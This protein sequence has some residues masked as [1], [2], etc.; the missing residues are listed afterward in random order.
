[1]AAE[2]TRARSLA[3]G[4]EGHSAIFQ[5]YRKVST[6]ARHRDVF[7][8]GAVFEHH[9][10]AMRLRI[11]N[12]HRAVPVRLTS[13]IAAK[14]EAEGKVDV[15]L[16]SAQFPEDRSFVPSEFKATENLSRS[17]LDLGDFSKQMKLPILVDILQRMY[18]ESDAEYLIYTNVDIGLYPDFYTKVNQF[19]E[20]GLDAFIINRRRISEEYIS[21][22][23]LVAIYKDKGKKHPGFDCFVFHRDLFPKLVLKEVCIGVPFIGITL[24]QNLFALSK[25]FKL[26]ENE[27][28]TFHIGMEIIKGRASREYFKY[29]QKQF[30]SAMNSPLREHLAVKKLPYSH[31]LL[32]FRLI[33]WGLQPS[34]PIRLML[35]LEMER[36]AGYFRKN[37]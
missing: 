21:V 8:D 15:E 36:L 3:Y 28:L 5:P 14:K 6:I 27:I 19:I 31:L 13:M 11:E 17:V 9:L 16:L 23:D 37:K 10:G 26:Y 22:D 1:M 33:R 7:G 34:F 29:N 32:P 25:N 24:S 18:E 20:S 4:P 12:T 30:W 2:Q 35:R